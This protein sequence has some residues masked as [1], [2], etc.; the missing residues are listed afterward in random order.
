M[1]KTNIEY[2]DRTWNPLAGCAIKSE[3]CVNCWAAAM[4]KRLRA[5]GRP[6]YQDV[7]DA[8]G[9]WTGKIT[10]IPER[11]GEP[12]KWRKP[13]RVLVEY[14]GD[15]FHDDVSDEYLLKVFEIMR[16][17]RKHT[18][19]VLTKRPRRMMGFIQG[20]TS[21]IE[22]LENVYLGVSIENDK[23][24]EERWADFSE[25][26]EMGWKTWVSYEPALSKV[27]WKGWEFLNQLVCGGESGARARIM[28]PNWARSARDF[29]TANDIPFFFKQWGDW[30]PMDHL[31]WITD[32]TTFRHKPIDWDGTMMCCVGKGMAG[33]VL[34]GREWSEMPQG[35]GGQ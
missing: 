26:S 3:G 1:S 16:E 5:M 33:R 10:L 4:A 15:L 18:Y 32:S 20:L 2:G 9:H 23:R 7:V 19:Q 13:Q 30:A 14:M 8:R 34:D 6:E 22:P 31:P 29:C 24:A 17:T 11:L 12:L 25:V 35:D 21:R 27:D 28:H